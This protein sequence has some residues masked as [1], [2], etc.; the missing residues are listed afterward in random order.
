MIQTPVTEDITY[1]TETLRT[2][3]DQLVMLRPSLEAALFKLGH[4]LP[5]INEGLNAFYNARRTV[6]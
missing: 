3:I 6:H 1:L 4:A 5:E 2:P